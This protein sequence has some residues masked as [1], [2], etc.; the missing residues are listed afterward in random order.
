MNYALVFS[1]ARARNNRMPLNLEKVTDVHDDVFLYH[2][3]RRR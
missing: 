2:F 3:G 1:H